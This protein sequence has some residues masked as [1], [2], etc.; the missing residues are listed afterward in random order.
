MLRDGVF[1]LR[2]A[3][4][5]ALAQ[6]GGVVERAGD[7]AVLTGGALGAAAAT[8]PNLRGRRRPADGRPSPPR[9]PAGVRDA[10]VLRRGYERLVPKLRSLGADAAWTAPAAT[11]EAGGD[12]TGGGRRR[13][14]EYW[15]PFAPA[16]APEVS[17]CPR[18]RLTAAAC[19]A[20][21]LPARPASPPLADHH[22]EG[23]KKVVKLIPVKAGDLTLT[24]PGDVGETEAGQTGCGW[25]S[26]PRRPPRGVK[27]PTEVTIFG[28]FGGTD[29][30]NLARWRDQFAA[31]GPRGVG[32]RGQ[33][34]GGQLQ[35]AGRDRQLERPGRPADDAQN[36][37]EA[38]QPDARRDRRGPGEGELLPE[39]DRPGEDGRR[40]GRGVSQEL[41]GGEG[42][43]EGVRS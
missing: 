26:S 18:R 38:G 7:R 3:H 4:L 21:L 29:E 27:D 24:G 30:A 40:P 39:D 25:L 10:G 15:P 42:D 20:A 8:A 31:E 9:A 22:E 12:R 34:P 33:G 11:E 28:G 2:T 23:E 41:R 35:A 19:L 16:P 37:V 13:R 17:S 32:R 6:F 36:R 43:G 14:A 5:P 1:P